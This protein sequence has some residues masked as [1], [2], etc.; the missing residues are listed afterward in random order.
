MRFFLTPKFFSIQQ[1][2]TRNKQTNNQTIKQTGEQGAIESPFGQSGKF[3]ARF[4]GG[5]SEAT[6]A[7]IPQGKG[8][9]K[10]KGKDKAKAEEEVEDEEKEVEGEGGT[11]RPQVILT[12]KKYI[13]DD[14]KRNVQ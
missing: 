6:R 11:K 10:N 4:P 12:F 1:E 7:L 9:G 8:K 13:F 14:Q 3:K 2:K 5:L